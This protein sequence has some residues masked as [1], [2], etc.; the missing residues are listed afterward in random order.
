MQTRGIY[1]RNYQPAQLPASQINQI[2]YA[3]ANF[4]SDGTVYVLYSML[5]L[6]I[7]LS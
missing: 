3:F 7:L 2:V 4:R 6:E 5:F 1:G